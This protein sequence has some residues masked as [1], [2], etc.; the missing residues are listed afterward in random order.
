MEI[1]ES[2]II[3]LTPAQLQILK[4]AQKK[5]AVNSEDFMDH[6]NEYDDYNDCHGD[7]YDAD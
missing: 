4:I 7:Y 5:A 1:D 6:W 2:T 3:E